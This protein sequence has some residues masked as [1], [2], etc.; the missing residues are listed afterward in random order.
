MLQA[1][2]R[3]VCAIVDAFHFQLPTAAGDATSAGNAAALGALAREDP[4]SEQDVAASA[5]VEQDILR[6]LQHRVLPNLECTLVRP[7]PVQHLL[8][9]RARLQ[10]PGLTYGIRL[11][12]VRAGQAI[13]PA[14]ALAAVKLLRLLPVT[15]SRTTLPRILQGVANLLRNRLQHVRQGPGH[16]INVC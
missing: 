2:V 14:V 4:A 12:V 10:E 11:Q 9:L 5:D 7:P 8:P 3:A 6:C 15:T 1:V 13:R 16:C